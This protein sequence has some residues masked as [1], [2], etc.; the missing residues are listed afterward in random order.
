L[1]GPSYDTCGDGILI[2]MMADLGVKTQIEARP[3]A[4]TMEIATGG[5]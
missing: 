2:R 1:C 5:I 4:V 3:I